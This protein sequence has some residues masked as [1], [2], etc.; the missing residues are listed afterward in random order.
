MEQALLQL[1]APANL[2]PSDPANAFLAVE[3]GF[4][5]AC[6]HLES[7]GVAQPSSLTLYAFYSRVRHYT[8]QKAS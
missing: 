2:R 8:Q 1:I 3:S 6:I 7:K 4:E 5:R